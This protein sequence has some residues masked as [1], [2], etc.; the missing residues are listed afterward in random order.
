VH[1]QAVAS[2]NAHDTVHLSDLAVYLVDISATVL[3]L[4]QCG[5]AAVAAVLQVHCN[6]NYLLACKEALQ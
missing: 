6:A 3:S 5:G 4:T 2:D 1:A